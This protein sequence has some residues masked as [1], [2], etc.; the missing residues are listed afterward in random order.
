MTKLPFHDTIIGSFFKFMFYFG[1]REIWSGK[2]TEL[3]VGTSECESKGSLGLGI[4]QWHNNQPGKGKG[5]VSK[6]KEKRRL[7]KRAL[8]CGQLIFADISLN[9]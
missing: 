3:V 6:G 7:P 8:G 1:Q 2:T 5:L 4:V 9:Y